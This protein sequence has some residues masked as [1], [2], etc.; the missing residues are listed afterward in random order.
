[1]EDEYAFFEALK[2]GAKMRGDVE[3]K[4]LYWNRKF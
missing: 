1:M 4:H 3:E 2:K